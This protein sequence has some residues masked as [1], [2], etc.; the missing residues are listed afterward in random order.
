MIKL[1]EELLAPIITGCIFVE[2]YQGLVYPV[3][4]Y[5]E[6]ANGLTKETIFPTSCGMDQLTCFAIGKHNPVIP[7]SS[8]K[9]LFYFED[10]NGVTFTGNEG[11]KG[12]ISN[13][14]GK[15]RLVAF[16][17]Y[18]KMGIED[19]NIDYKIIHEL[20]KKLTKSPCISPDSKSQISVT[21][22]V[23]VPKSA[24]N[25]FGKYSY[26]KQMTNLLLYPHSYFALDINFQLK[27]SCIDDFELGEEINCIKV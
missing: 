14:T 4:K 19:C 7:N 21:S 25:I 1:A 2:N 16:L 9:S 20:I 8:E 6:L 5:D 24:S 23:E 12:A 13:Y 15:I 10:V 22:V 17:N 18:Q 26:Y 27:V 11:G 3:S